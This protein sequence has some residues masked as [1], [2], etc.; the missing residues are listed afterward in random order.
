[1]ID[2][3]QCKLYGI[4]NKKYLSELLGI[5]VFKLKDVN[6]YYFTQPFEKEFKNGKKRSLYN[7]SKEY[8]VVLKKMNFYLQQITPPYY[9]FGG[10][11][12][13]D[14]AKNASLHKESNYF[15]QLDLK[16]FF[17]ST[18][19]FYVFNFFKYK[20]S[21]SIDISK[22]CTM[23]VT[24][25]NISD[26]NIRFLPQGYSTSPLLS[27]LCYFDMYN[28]I[29]SIVQKEDMAFSCYYDD[30]SFSSMKFINKKFKEKIVNVIK[31]YDLQINPNKTQFKKNLHGIRVT[32][33][34]IK[35]HDLS[36]PNKLQLKMYKYFEELIFVYSNY[37]DKKEEIIKLCN[38][39]NG[40][41]SSIRSVETT[42]VFPHITN[43]VREIRKLI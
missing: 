37:P 20:L 5:D 24:E 43:K 27:Y 21:M 39:V 38:I 7:P 12:K 23:L 3:K 29:H 36:A 22:I 32:G 30:I 34:I 33:T 40:C 17:P 14:Y 9:I 4:Q 35:N 18:R 2:F 11:K 13:R 6:S 16:D 31:E 10:I 26:S 41:V 15:L 8:R 42:R 1:M 19:D 25:P 28:G